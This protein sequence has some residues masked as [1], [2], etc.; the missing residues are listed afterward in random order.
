MKRHVNMK[1]AIPVMGGILILL[2][3][4]KALGIPGIGT[5][6]S[7]T[8]M[9]FVGNDSIHKYNGT[10][11]SIKGTFIH[12]LSPSKDSNSIHCE[13]QSKSGS[14]HVVILEKESGN[15]IFE[16]EIFGDAEF[17]VAAGGKVKITLT[18]Q[19]HEGS[20]LFQY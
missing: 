6:N 11:H 18:T 14:L 3:I 7:G 10:Y 12:S 20:Y 17:D 1:I 8:R 19:G 13:V 5:L 4:L 16:Q 2:V 9:G 15:V